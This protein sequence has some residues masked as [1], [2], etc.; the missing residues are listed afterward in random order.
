MPQQDNNMY[1]DVGQDEELMGND[2]DTIWGDLRSNEIQYADTYGGSEADQR[3][4][5]Y[6]DPTGYDAGVRGLTGGIRQGEQDYLDWATKNE[7]SAFDYRGDPNKL[8]AEKVFLNTDGLTKDQA[9]RLFQLQE[10]EMYSYLSSKGSWVDDKNG[11][12]FEWDNPSFAEQYAM[13]LAELALNLGTGGMYNAAKGFITSAT[14][15]DLGGALQGIA[16]GYVS[17]LGMDIKELT[18]AAE[19]ATL[20]GDWVKSFELQN[21]IQN[22][23]QTA[24]GV[25]AL[26]ALSQGN[27][28]AALDSGLMSQGVGN[29]SS[30]LTNVLS[31][32]NGK[33][34]GV[35]DAAPL[36]QAA[37]KYAG[38]G[39]VQDALMTY[40]RSGG[41]IA[42]LGEGIDINTPEF[43]KEFERT[44]LRPA[45]DALANFDA[46]YLQPMYQP[47]AGAIG[48]V[49][50][51]VGGLNLG[52][53][54][55]GLVNPTALA[56]LG[57]TGVQQPMPQQREYTLFENPYKRVTA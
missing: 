28:L 24:S 31:D 13:P 43:L 47:V 18:D 9:M 5:Y 52:G 40:I 55:S 2:L 54:F 57:G 35:L 46:N 11:I 15:G 4:A 48:D 3:M 20:A 33:F 17:K 12:R 29:L 25:N 23:A 44:Y 26:N 50:G 6:A 30:N 56:G 8:Q 1:V 10:P 27:Y 39:D 21:Q 32:A 19:A 51:A 37:I 42:G 36:S 45:G 14:K 34:M 38:G 41:S 22:M 53:L 16:E 7:V 49:A